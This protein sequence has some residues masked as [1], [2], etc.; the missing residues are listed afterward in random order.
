[1][2]PVV[3]VVGLGGAEEVVDTCADGVGPVIWMVTKVMESAWER[4][5][6]RVTILFSEEI[7]E[8][9]GSDMS[10]GHTPD[11][12]LQVWEYDLGSGQLVELET[13]LQGIGSLSAAH[14]N[15]I[16]VTV[17]EFV[18]ENGAD[19]KTRN[20]VSMRTPSLLRDQLL[21]PPHEQNRPVAVDLRTPPPEPSISYPS[22][23][24]PAP[25]NPLY[26]P[27]V[28]T[29][30]HEPLARHW[31]VRN[32][33]G[34]IISFTIPQLPRGE[35][36]KGYF[37]IYDVAGNLVHADANSDLFEGIVEDVSAF[38]FEVFWN[39]YNQNGMEVASGV[40]RY[41]IKIDYQNDN[42]KDMRLFGTIGIAK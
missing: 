6:D 35:R 20:L 38:D 26:P 13:V 31:V 37:K 14:T 36:V 24:R 30:K 39:G 1:M 12:L 7:A 28:F 8:Q 25:T 42:R 4:A 27:G 29:F 40:Y 22:P 23:A 21:N 34:A 3:E 33:Q 10:I 41:I 11:E 15:E 17:I 16:G 2:R 19:L 32:G 5:T 9:G 18:M